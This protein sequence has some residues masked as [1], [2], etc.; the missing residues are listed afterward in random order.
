MHNVGPNS[1]GDESWRSA[2]MTDMKDV[3]AEA[4]LPANGIRQ[5][6]AS[7]DNGSWGVVI[8]KKTLKTP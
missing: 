8:V 6:F 7:I 4:R 1:P 5:S 3:I 2:T